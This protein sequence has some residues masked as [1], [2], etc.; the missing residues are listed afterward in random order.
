MTMIR[1]CVPLNQCNYGSNNKELA[2][3]SKIRVTTKCKQDLRSWTRMQ[4]NEY[5]DAICMGQLRAFSPWTRK[6]H[7]GMVQTRSVTRIAEEIR[8]KFAWA[9][10]GLRPKGL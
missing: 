6:G 10:R 8:R 2:G 9:P 5:Y 3:K 7:Q 4:R 1:P